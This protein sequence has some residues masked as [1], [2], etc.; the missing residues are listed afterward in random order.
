MARGAKSLG[1]TGFAFLGANLA[2]LIFEVSGVFASSPSPENF[3]FPCIVISFRCK[4][5]II[6]GW[7]NAFQL[8]LVLS[9]IEDEF[10]IILR[11]GI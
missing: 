6:K 10:E 7:T 2:L 4:I 11:N 9:Q 1:D 3:I 5:N 8:I